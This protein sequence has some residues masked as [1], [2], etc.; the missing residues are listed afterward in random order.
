M[1]AGK[2]L[3]RT[4]LHHNFACLPSLNRTWLEAPYRAF[5]IR[6]ALNLSILYD[7]PTLNSVRWRFSSVLFFILQK[8]SVMKKIFLFFFTYSVLAGIQSYSKNLLPSSIQNSFLVLALHFIFGLQA[9]VFKT[10]PQNIRWCVCSVC[11]AMV[12]NR[13]AY[14]CQW[15]ELLFLDI[16]YAT[17]WHLQSSW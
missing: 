5:A 1:K 9:T 10:C 14:V 2:K 12:G 4:W 15:V 16:F 11:T 7:I 8:R 17:G 13:D 6:S 3:R